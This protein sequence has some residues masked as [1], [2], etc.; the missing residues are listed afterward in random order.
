ML[1]DS[2]KLMAHERIV[3]PIRSVGLPLTE[4]G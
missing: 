2:S 3:A 4:F 1:F